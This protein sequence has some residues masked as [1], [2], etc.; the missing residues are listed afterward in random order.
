MSFE[1]RGKACETQVVST[2]RSGTMRRMDWGLQRRHSSKL[3]SPQKNMQL[4]THSNEW[5]QY[6]SQPQYV[7]QSHRD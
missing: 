1:N 6:T 5:M 7:V 3:R 2:T 4:T